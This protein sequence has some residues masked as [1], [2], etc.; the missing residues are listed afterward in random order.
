MSLRRTYHRLFGY[1]ERFHIAVVLTIVVVAW[2]VVPRV[3]EFL[4]AAGG[5][6]PTDYEPKDLARL[7]WLSRQVSSTV[8][9]SWEIVIDVLLLLLVAVVWLTFVPAPTPR[10]RPPGR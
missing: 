4:D 5:Y 2:V 8:R 7:E 3:V 6:A 1:H 9:V 10:R